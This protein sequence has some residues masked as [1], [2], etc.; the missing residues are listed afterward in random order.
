MAFAVVKLNGQ[1][2]FPVQLTLSNAPRCQYLEDLL[3]GGVCFV[4]HE[5]GYRYV[6]RLDS[7]G[8]KRC[9]KGTA[10]GDI[11]VRVL[12]PGESINVAINE[13]GWSPEEREQNRVE[14]RQHSCR[15]DD[16]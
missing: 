10:R 8:P 1:Q 2:H 3:H 11:P 13:V 12:Q 4:H 16:C 15:C 5:G 9:D 14:R 7:L 6:R